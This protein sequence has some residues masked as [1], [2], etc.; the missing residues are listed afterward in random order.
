MRDVAAH[1]DNAAKLLYLI[2]MTGRKAA[3]IALR[4]AQVCSRPRDLRPKR[5]IDVGI[6]PSRCVDV[7]IGDVKELRS[8]RNAKQTVALA[9]VVPGEASAVEALVIAEPRRRATCAPSD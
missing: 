1:A 3:D 9:N 6:T 8:R 5:S 2:L 7:R 4:V